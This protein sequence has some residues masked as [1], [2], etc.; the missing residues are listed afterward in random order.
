MSKL[1]VQD[2]N[3]KTI[4]V[5]FRTKCCILFIIG[6]LMLL[7]WIILILKIGPIVQ[8]FV[9]IFTIV[10]VFVLFVLLQDYFYIKT[11]TK[12]EGFKKDVSIM[13]FIAPERKKKK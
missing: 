7:T 5:G 1:I 11:H 2:K 6:H 4:D 10:S 3:N 13:E 9:L 12:N 8:L